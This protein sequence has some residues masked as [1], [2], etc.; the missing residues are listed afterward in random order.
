MRVRAAV[1]L[2]A[3]AGLAPASCRKVEA[4][5]LDPV[6]AIR[7]R[8][9]PAFS[10]PADGLLTDAEIDTFIRVRKASGRRPPSEVAGEMEVDPAEFAWVR[11]RIGEALM[12]LDAQRATEAAAGSYA[13]ALAGLRETRRTTRDVRTAAR[14]DAEI[15]ALERERS[16]LRRPI[17]ASPASR[18][19]AR[20]APRRAELEQIGP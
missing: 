3:T 9:R 8:V 16:S 14:I 12:A 18:N 7:E 20:I 2:A 4:P 17:P 6:R 19:A 13:E 5:R 10:P 15:A 11:A 1:L